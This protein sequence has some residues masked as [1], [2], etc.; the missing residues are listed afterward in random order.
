VLWSG[1]S[2]PAVRRANELLGRYIADASVVTVAGTAH[3]MIAT[4]PQET[5]RAAAQHMA[6]AQHP[7]G[8]SADRRAG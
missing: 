1:A 4:H 8:R 6:R 2:H 7:L 3:F 5:A